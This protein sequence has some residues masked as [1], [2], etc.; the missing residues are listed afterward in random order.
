M[1][2]R[3]IGLFGGTFN[4]V[5]KTHIAVAEI[6]FNKCS[7]DEI[8]FIPAA[9]PPHKSSSIVSFEHRQEMVQRA[10]AGYPAFSVSLIEGKLSS[11]YPPKTY[12]TFI[13]GADAFLDIESW[14]EYEKLLVMVNLILLPRHGVSNTKVCALLQKL[15]YRQQNGRWIFPGANRIVF[16]LSCPPPDLSSTQIRKKI[17]KGQLTGLSQLVDLQILDYIKAN[18]LY[19][20]DQQF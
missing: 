17:A 8:V 18:E 7:L 9:S 6:A 2:G 1:K 20:R 16:F 5:H 13:M 12:F 14:K 10:V 19:I 15:G 3:N 4:P 11:V